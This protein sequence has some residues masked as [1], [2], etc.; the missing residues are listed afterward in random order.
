MWPGLSNQRLHPLTYN[1]RSVLHLLSE[2]SQL[3]KNSPCPGKSIDWVRVNTA[4][5]CT[6]KRNHTGAVDDSAKERQGQLIGG[7]YFNKHL[8]ITWVCCVYKSHNSDQFQPFDLFWKNAYG[9]IDNNVALHRQ[10]RECSWMRPI[11]ETL[12]YRSRSN[13]NSHISH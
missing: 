7:M 9:F 3:R 8:Q 2:P 1:L 6:G 11:S 10:Q 13:Y 5:F 12:K 4:L